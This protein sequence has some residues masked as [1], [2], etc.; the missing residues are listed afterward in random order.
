MRMESEGCGM[1]LKK[2]SGTDI[3]TQNLNNE[4]QIQ[5]LIGAVNLLMEK[6]NIDFSEAELKQIDADALKFM[7]EQYPDNDIK[8]V[9]EAH[10]E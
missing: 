6:M 1:G 2:I 10:N 3:F 7:Q 9:S 5:R 4:Y 8:Y